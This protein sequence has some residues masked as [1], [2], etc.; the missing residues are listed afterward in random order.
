MKRLWLRICVLT[1]WILPQRLGVANITTSLHLLQKVELL[2]LPSTLNSDWRICPVERR[3]I[4]ILET[5]YTSHS[6]DIANLVVSF[7]ELK[8]SFLIRIVLEAFINSSTF[9]FIVLT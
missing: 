8:I 7:S 9:E 4:Y 6:F 1:I 3:Y 2:L 5:Q